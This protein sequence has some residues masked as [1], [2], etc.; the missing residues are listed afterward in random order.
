MVCST[1]HPFSSAH[2]AHMIAEM[3]RRSLE[4]AGSTPFGAG[5]RRE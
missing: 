3:L 1:T 2:V 4:S 5:K